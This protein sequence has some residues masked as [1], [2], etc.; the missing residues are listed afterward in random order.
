MQ[1]RALA[2]EI[3][4]LGGAKWLK[5]TCLKDDLKRII[6]LLVPNHRL[7]F[8]SPGVTNKKAVDMG[9]L[10]RA[11]YAA[12]SVMTVR[13]EV[14]ETVVG[15]KKRKGK[16]RGGTQAKKPKSGKPAAAT[17]LLDDDFEEG[18][19]EDEGD[20]EEEEEE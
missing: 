2:G 1:D 14:E 6:C 8:S 11:I 15:G 4:K 16:G 12:L 19:E 3:E 18:D 9:S 10:T 7:L 20:E 13:A 17:A 5:G